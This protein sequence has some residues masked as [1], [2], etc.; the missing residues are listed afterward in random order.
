VDQAGEI[1]LL[2]RIYYKDFDLTIENLLDHI[3]R[4]IQEVISSANLP[5]YG[6]G[7]SSPGLQMESGHGTL[8]SVNMPTLNGVDLYDY[9]KNRFKF[10]IVVTNDLVAQSL[11]ESYFGVG[12]GVERFLSVSLGTGIGHTFILNGKPQLTINGVSG[13]SGRIILDPNSETKDSSGVFGSAEALCGVK[14]IEI[15]ATRY[16]L[17]ENI[18]S[19]LKIISKARESKN[20]EAIEIMSI[21]SRRLALLLINLS[22]IYFPEVIS[23]SGGQTEAGQFFIDECQKEF[24]KRGSI[25]FNAINNS[26]GRE[27][28]IKIKKSDAGGLA[29]LCGSIVP[30]LH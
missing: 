19:A 9:F 11:S 13:D 28:N 25:F 27:Q 12:K 24:D 18:N 20:P 8:I 17:A 21:I 30:L 6:M 1:T 26:L 29:A 3:L 14:A 22:A 10:P 2:N 15:L 16:F 4:E 23:I 5:I 7:I